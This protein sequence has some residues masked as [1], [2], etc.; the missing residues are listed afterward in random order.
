MSIGQRQMVVM[1]NL[2]I[3]YPLALSSNQAIVKFHNWPLQTKFFILDRLRDRGFI[4]DISKDPYHHKWV[5]TTSGWMMLDKVKDA[6]V[7]ILEWGTNDLPLKIDIRKSR[8]PEYQILYEKAEEK[9][10]EEE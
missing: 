7:S 6:P 1:T 2:A 3:H 10:S 9:K 4:E 5:L 8:K